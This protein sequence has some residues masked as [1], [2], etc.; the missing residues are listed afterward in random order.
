MKKEKAK[1]HLNF[2]REHLQW[3]R[4]NYVDRMRDPNFQNLNNNGWIGV[5]PYKEWL[6]DI[7]QEMKDTKERIAKF[8]RIVL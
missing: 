4:E 7:K 2:S 3:L 6:A 1:K 8:E 5:N